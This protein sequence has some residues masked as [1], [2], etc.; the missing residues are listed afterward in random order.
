MKKIIAIA[1]IAAVGA[2]FGEC[3]DPTDCV[4]A[5][6]VSLSGKSAVAASTKA[7]PSQ[8]IDAECYRKAASFK[9]KGYIY[10]TTEVTEANPDEC[11]DGSCGCN[12]FAEVTS[13][14]W[15]TK[16][17]KKVTSDFKFDSIARI[18]SAVSAKAKTVEI[19]ASADDA[20]TFAGFGKYDT[21]K[22]FL[23]SASGY[24]AGKLPL[25]ECESCSYDKDNCEDVCES[26]TSTAFA[27]CSDEASDV[28]VVP[29]YGKWT[30][31]Y[32]KS[33]VKKLAK[34]YADD[35]IVPAKV[36]AKNEGN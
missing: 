29:A 35:A 17:L 15:N 27:V 11:I 4:F 22:A 36:L 12:E 7:K 25:P 9:A 6:Q 26:T 8:C 20:L 16:T 31:K 19:L 24:F 13:Y 3:Q 10:G 14:I 5:Y 23:K 30:I 33:A 18:G 28:D 2:A 32:S 34:N 1:A 21:K